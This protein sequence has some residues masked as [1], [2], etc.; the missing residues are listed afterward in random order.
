[1]DVGAFVQENRR[2]LIG[3]AIGFVVYLIAGAVIRSIYDPSSAMSGLRA[4]VQR[5]PKELYGT[6]QR[7]DLYDEQEKLVAQRERLERTLAFKRGTEYQ[8]TAGTDAGSFLFEA[9]RKLKTEIRDR[10]DERNI[11]VGDSAVAW[12]VPTGVADIKRV[13]FGLELLDE[14]VERLFAAH[15][16]TKARDEDAVGLRSI[17]QLR[18][19]TEK[20][21]SRPT[22]RQGGRDAV[23]LRD[24]VE[25]EKLSFK[26]EA[27]AP[28]LTAFFEACRQSD[29]T[30]VVERVTMQQP[31]RIG[32]PV[33]VTGVLTGIAFKKP[34]TESE[35]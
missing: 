8:V 24:Y 20:R 30:L 11:D 22:Y 4:E 25:Q 12:T 7:D 26:F 3:C 17:M 27:D 31:E 2:W 35:Q 6:S 16:A 32:E 13:L 29:R 9:G 33:V 21:S 1:M 10:A 34:E 28:T 15:D 23:D 5:L 18:A 19:E 14:A